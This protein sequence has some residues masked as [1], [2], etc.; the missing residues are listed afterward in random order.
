MACTSCHS[1]HRA[2]S[3]RALLR[4][5]Q[6]PLCEECHT[7]VR[8]QFAMPFKHRVEEGVMSCTDCHN[9]HGSFAPTWRMA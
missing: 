4:K 9:P 8:S 1:V 3:V 2:Q 6:T 7:D 5:S